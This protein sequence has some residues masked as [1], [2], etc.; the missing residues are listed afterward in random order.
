VGKIIVKKVNFEKYKDIIYSLRKEV[1]I[2]EQKVPYEIEIDNFDKISDHFLLFLEKKAIAYG[3]IRYF[4]NYAK[5]ERIA[6]LKKFRKKGYGKKISEFMIIHCK[7]IGINKILLHS[8]KHV[9]DFYQKIGFKEFGNFFYEADI[10][11]RKMEKN[12]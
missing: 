1:F 8:Q 4:D 5:F 12:I 3:R 6:V 9:I 7:K 2:D 10:K 11:H